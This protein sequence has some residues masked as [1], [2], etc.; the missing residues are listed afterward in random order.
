M[1]RERAKWAICAG[2]SGTY[3]VARLEFCATQRP[4]ASSAASD[5]AANFLP[6]AQRV[7]KAIGAWCT[8]SHYHYKT[9]YLWRHLGPGRRDEPSLCGIP[10]PRPRLALVV[11]VRP[12]RD[13]ST[14]TFVADLE[15][16]Q[17]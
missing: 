6:M 8:A 9:Q 14:G 1:Y 12:D 5:L 3:M 2:S 4:A 7:R 13:E 15:H 11:A 16:E 10:T 17:N